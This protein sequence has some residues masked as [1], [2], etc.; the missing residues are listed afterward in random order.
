MTVFVLRLV[1]TCHLLCAVLFSL[2]AVGAGLGFASPLLDSLNHFQLLW[3]FGTLALLLMTAPLYTVYRLRAA[4]M[5]LTATGFLASAVIV[6]P[7]ALSAFLPRDPWTEDGRPVYRLLT[8]NMFGMNYSYAEIA[9]MIAREDPDIL[10]LQEYFPE[11]RAGLGAVLS[12]AYPYSER[13]TGPKRTN[14][15]IY[16]KLPFTTNSGGDCTSEDNGRTAQLIAHFTPDATPAFDVMT[17]QLDW[18]VQI[19]QWNKGSNFLDAMA[20]MTARQQNQFA[21]LAEAVDEIKAPLILTGDFNSTSWSYTLRGFV[22]ETGLD[23]RTHNLWTYPKL[24]YIDGWRKTPA[25]LP[26]DQVMTKN[27]ISVHDV[28]TGRPAGSDHL[29]VVVDFSVDPKR[30]PSRT[31]LTPED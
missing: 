31:I 6:I 14:I 29:P 28:H 26:L 27:A 8:Y 23:R 5:A 25:F 19:S 17:T 21:E 1:Q 24:F 20:R 12:A 30:P 13:C 2:L 3:F 9:D 10:T 7:E 18:P 16:A 4:L 22:R 15:A 11:Q